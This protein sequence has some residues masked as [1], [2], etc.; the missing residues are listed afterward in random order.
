LLW[1]GFFLCFVFPP[2]LSWIYLSYNVVVE[3]KDRATRF[4][5]RY[6]ETLFK[7]Y[8]REIEVVNQAENGTEDLLGDL[9]SII[10]SFCA[11]LYGQRMA[12]R[13]T[14]NIVEELIK[15][16]NEDAAS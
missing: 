8:G 13:K 1:H 4:G 3:H 6:I 11:R 7:T 9:Q 5:F 2:I 16:G 15:K 10:Y 12:K 14:E